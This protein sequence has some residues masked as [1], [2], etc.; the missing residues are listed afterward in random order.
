MVIS[1]ALYIHNVHNYTV[2]TTCYHCAYMVIE[3]RYSKA[4]L[5]KDNT[6]HIGKKLSRN[7]FFVYSSVGTTVPVSRQTPDQ[8]WRIRLL[9]L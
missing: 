4:Q 1:L 7:M 6:F 9:P 2:H 3:K 8:R 5:T